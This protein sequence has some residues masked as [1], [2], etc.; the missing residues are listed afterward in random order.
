VATKKISRAVD[1]SN[2]DSTSTESPRSRSRSTGRVPEEERQAKVEAVRERVAAV[3][4]R[5]RGQNE[6]TV[7]DVPATTAPVEAEAKQPETDVVAAETIDAA[8]T[9]L[10]PDAE[11]PEKAAEPLP[12]PEQALPQIDEAFRNELLELKASNE[13]L[14]ALLS[15]VPERLVSLETNVDVFQQHRISQ[16][17]K[18]AELESTSRDIQQAFQNLQ[19]QL[20]QLLANP[21]KPEAPEVVEPEPVVKATETPEFL[22][23]SAANEVLKARL[24]DLEEKFAQQLGL[25]EKLSQDLGQ[26]QQDLE[27]VIAESKQREESLELFIQQLHSREEELEELSV[28]NEELDNQ[29]GRQAAEFA[30]EKE[31]LAEQLSASASEETLLQLRILELETSLHNA[32]EAGNGDQLQDLT[33]RHKELL[34]DHKELQ[35]LHREL[36]DEYLSETTKLNEERSQLTRDLEQARDQL[37]ISSGQYCDQVDAVEK[38]TMQ[39]TLCDLTIEETEKV[40]DSL[41]PPP[42]SLVQPIK[43]LRGRIQ[44]LRAQQNDMKRPDF[45]TSKAQIASLQEELLSTRQRVLEAHTEIDRLETQ[46]RKSL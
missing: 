16:G 39:L 32:V 30:A 23:L 18:L 3:Q 35:Q 13:R 12:L 46:L 21:P 43:R 8:V 4:A 5:K 2:K 42:P 17:E 38:L 24:L 44:E 29:L 22:A 20:A 28:L 40:L 41:P 27:K 6:K 9:N 45:K 34:E 14:Q 1:R 19:E 33:L 10:E 26:Q 11:A 31:K 36:R 37:M 7:E 15:S 25:N